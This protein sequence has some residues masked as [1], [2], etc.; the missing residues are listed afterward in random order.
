MVLFKL[1]EQASNEAN[2]CIFGSE[3]IN[4]IYLL[5]KPLCIGFAAAENYKVPYW[6]VQYGLWSASTCI[7]IRTVSHGNLNCQI[8]SE[9]LSC[10]SH[11]KNEDNFY[12]TEFI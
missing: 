4:P 9:S 10:F 5:F 1:P 2:L 6:C 3:T 11:L 8:N 12:F 7:W